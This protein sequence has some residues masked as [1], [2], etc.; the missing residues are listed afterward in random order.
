MNPST[1][2]NCLVPFYLRYIRD[3]SD[4]HVLASV[5]DIEL[6]IWNVTGR[7]VEVSPQ[8]EDLCDSFGHQHP[9][10]VEGL[11]R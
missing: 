11:V 8:P 5:L 10:A 1:M 4:A 2:L 3:R 7:F 6:G 9:I